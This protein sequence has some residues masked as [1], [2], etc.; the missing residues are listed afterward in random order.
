MD[1]ANQPTLEDLNFI[2][3]MGPMPLRTRAHPMR[4]HRSDSSSDEHMPSLKL[5]AEVD[6]RQPTGCRCVGRAYV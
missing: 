4:G 3:E 1:D 5:T 2:R 6:L